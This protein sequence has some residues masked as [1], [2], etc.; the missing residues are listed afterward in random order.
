MILKFLLL[1]LIMIDSYGIVYLLKQ[2]NVTAKVNRMI[3]Q[4]NQQYYQ[5]MLKEYQKKKVTKAKAKE[6]I[7]Q[8]IASLTRKAQIKSS[9]LFHPFSVVI[10]CI[11]F[12]GIGLFV[13]Y[14]FFQ[15]RGLTIISSVPIAF[16]PI[17]LLEMKA[18]MNRV[19]IEKAVINFLLQL[20][21]YTN[22]NNDII[23]A[24]KQVKTVEPLQGYIN[25]FLIQNNSGALSFCLT[26]FS[27]LLERAYHLITFG[28]EK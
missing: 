24:M 12:F 13:T 16:L 7:L 15:S 20:K 3:N 26:F 25:H 10:I 9:I 8:I 23:Y 4:K 28:N 27:F 5:K 19:K 14:P 1:L 21:N 18:E 17:Y 11:L 2:S 6:N 22:I